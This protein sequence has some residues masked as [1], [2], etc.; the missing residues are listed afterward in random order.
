[1]ASAVPES[2]IPNGPVSVVGWNDTQIKMYGLWNGT[3]DVRGLVGSEGRAWTI[4]D[5]RDGW[6]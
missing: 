5:V 2:T 1:M 6:D 3:R 4:G